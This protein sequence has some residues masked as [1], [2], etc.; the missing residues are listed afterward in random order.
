ML[1]A[2]GRQIHN[3]TVPP[4]DRQ[5]KLLFPD[6]PLGNLTVERISESTSTSTSNWTSFDGKFDATG[7]LSKYSDIVALMVFE[8]QMRGM[9]LLGRIGW[10][11]RVAEY[12]AQPSTAPAFNLPKGVADEVPIPLDAA[13]RELVDY[14]LF[15]DEAPLADRVQGS[16]GFAERFAAQGPRDRRGRSLR[17]LDLK[18]RLL[19]YPCSYLIYSDAFEALPPPAKRAIYERMR[20]VLS[21]GETDPRYRRLSQADRRAIIEILRD[22]KKDL[23]SYFE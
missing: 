21:G 3:A 7:Y 8:H 9:N 10:E 14:F 15:V 1:G 19:R 11:A 13:A 18:T 16:S 23:P 20:H 5:Y 17:E 2:Q 12:Q 4:A 6:R 22:T